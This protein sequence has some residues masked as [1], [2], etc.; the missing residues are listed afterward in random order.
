[1][2][3]AQF[4]EQFTTDRYRLG[5]KNNILRFLFDVH[6][7]PNIEKPHKT[8]KYTCKDIQT[9]YLSRKASVAFLVS[10]DDYSHDF[11]EKVY[12]NAG[13]NVRLYRKSDAAISCLE[14]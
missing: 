1:M 4:S 3:T 2:I 10:A 8:Y 14:E 5:Q 11:I 6:G 9:L 12:I 13:Y 7:Y